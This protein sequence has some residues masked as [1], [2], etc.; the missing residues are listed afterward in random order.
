MPNVTNALFH[1]MDFLVARQGV[2]A[3]N[4]AN[5][6][7]PGYLAKDLVDASA[8]SGAAAPLAMATT[9]GS[10]MVGADAGNGG[11]AMTEDSRF[12]QYNGNSV[13]IDQEMLKM[14]DVQMNYRMM[15][16]LYNKQVA[17]QMAAL[18]KQ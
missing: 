6:D 17:M 18:G 15:T 4:I 11:G 3:G 8:D 13:R 10:H 2:I 12:L 9:D 5:A 1:R 7:T 14:N 16:E